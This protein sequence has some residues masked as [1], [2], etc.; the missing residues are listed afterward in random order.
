MHRARA[1]FQLI[2]HPVGQQNVGSWLI[3]SPSSKLTT[4]LM[5]AS[6][7]KLYNSAAAEPFLNGSSSNYIDDMYNSWLRDPASVH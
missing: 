7:V 4:E 1:A 3:R 2:N 6:S 5:A